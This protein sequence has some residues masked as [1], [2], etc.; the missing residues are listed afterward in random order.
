MALIASLRLDSPDVWGLEHNKDESLGVMLA[1]I[2]AKNFD[3]SL[4]I[5][6][7][8]PLHAVV[9]KIKNRRQEQRVNKKPVNKPA[10]LISA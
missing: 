5:L 4:D 9:S 10:E 2:K 1:K 8:N 3:K 6:I 7:K